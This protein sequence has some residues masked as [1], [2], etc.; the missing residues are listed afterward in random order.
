[1]TALI[2][3]YCEFEALIKVEI[4]TSGG[5]LRTILSY[6]GVDKLWHPVVFFSKTI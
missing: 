3:A 5:Y 6:L 4:D 1:M 2:L